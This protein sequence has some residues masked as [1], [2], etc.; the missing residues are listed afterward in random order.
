MNQQPPDIYKDTAKLAR[1]GVALIHASGLPLRLFSRVPG[2]MGGGYMFPGILWGYLCMGLAVEMTTSHGIT[3]LPLFI[4]VTGWLWL[5]HLAC[6]LLS[7]R[8]GTGTYAWHTGIGWLNKLSDAHPKALAFLSDAVTATILAMFCT[9]QG[10][11]SLADW[12]VISIFL[13][14]A[15]T[16]LLDVRDFARRR[17]V[18]SALQEQRYWQ[19]MMQQ[20][21]NDGDM[22]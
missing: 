20:S 12:W 1:F 5:F 15:S 11:T 16:L 17:Q 18:S 21:L 4:Q 8:N 2:S 13:S 9:S 7:Y 14:L 6:Y 3:L 22:E 19:S 10:D